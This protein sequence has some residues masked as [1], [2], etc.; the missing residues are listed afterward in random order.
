MAK[1]KRRR[2]RK[3]KIQ[4]KAKPFKNVAKPVKKRESIFL[5]DP[6]LIRSDLTKTLVLSILAVATI[7]AI[8]FLKI[9]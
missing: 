9:I 4:A 3:Q 8:Y 7:V 2:T 5:Y 6:G 1:K